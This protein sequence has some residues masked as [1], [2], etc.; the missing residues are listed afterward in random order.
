VGSV[1]A[2][3][4]DGPPFNRFIYTLLPSDDDDDVDAAG[5]FAVDR[6]TGVVRTVRRLDRERR[7][8]YRLTA[9]ARELAHPRASSAVPVTVFVADRNDHAPVVPAN[10]SA[11]V[12]LYAAPGHVFARVAASDADR[13]LNAR[14]RYAIA[15]G[16][17]PAAAGA[18]AVGAGSGL[19]SVR[20]DL[21]AVLPARVTRLTLDLLVRDSGLPPLNATATLTVLIDR[22]ARDRSRHGAGPPRGG[23]GGGGGW[24]RSLAGGELRR[25]LVVVLAAGTAVVIVVLLLA[26]ICVRRRQL[27]ALAAGGVDQVLTP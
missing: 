6:D 12:S 9:V 11:A 20:R 19:V 4:R 27:A 22:T 25:E 16:D 3:D 26:I 1:T 13:G 7:A 5:A 15:G 24:L 23:G 21:G 10:Q 14:L 18:F 17:E 2:I 8:V